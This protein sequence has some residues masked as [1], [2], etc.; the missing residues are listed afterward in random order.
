M[1]GNLS[2]RNYKRLQAPAKCH[3]PDD[4]GA[5]RN[6]LFDIL[7]YITQLQQAPVLDQQRPDSTGEAGVEGQKT[8]AKSLKAFQ[9]LPAPITFAGAA[10]AL[11]ADPAE[12]AEDLAS[13]AP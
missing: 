8:S 12:A 13:T 9:P 11:A 10:L 2:W 1:K 6:Y 3:L 7:I 5:V 4:H